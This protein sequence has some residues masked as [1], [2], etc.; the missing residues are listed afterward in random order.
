[1]RLKLF[2]Q[3]GLTYLLLL[4]LVLLGVDIYTERTLRTGYILAAE[5]QLQALER[6]A[7]PRLPPL[8]DTA[9]LQQ[10]TRWAA[11]SGAR[12]TVI[13]SDGRVLSDSDENA[14]HMENH[15]GRPEIRSALASG[16]GNAVRFS[17]TV[18]RDL[19]YLAVRLERPGLPA[20]VLRFAMP[21]QQV[22][23][24]L[25]NIR[26]RLWL[27]SGTILLLAGAVSL[28]FSR[29]FSRRVDRLKQFSHRVAQGDFRAL[30]VG[31]SGD[32]LA[33]LAATLN[34]TARNLDQSIGALTEERNRSAAIL[35]SMAEAVALIDAGERIVFYNDA[36]RSA[37][38]LTAGDFQGRPFSDVMRHPEVAAAVRAALS[39]QDRR[40]EVT[41]AL[42]QR[43]TFELTAIPVYHAGTI[44][45]LL[46]LHDITELRRLERIRRD[47]VANV[48]HEFRTP[49]TAIQGFA[50]TLLSGALEDEQNSRRFLQIIRDHA[51]RLARLTEDL[52][53]LAQI[54]AGRLEIEEQPVAIADVVETCVE[55]S[56]LR[57]EQQRL[58]LSVDVP[59]S[60]P[61]VTGDPR[62]LRDVLQNL[63]D[64]AIQYTEPG[65][66]IRINA[67]SRNDEVWLAVADT[68]IGIPEA[69]QQRIFERFYRV[70]QA[71]S[72]AAG[73]TG[74]GL[75]IARH[76]VELHG[77]RI[78]VESQ[79]GRGSTFRVRLPAAVPASV[80]GN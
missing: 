18:H 47:F 16:T 38:G 27:A 48:S 63:L 2:W 72:R 21:L 73:G 41:V 57:L 6:M 68:G 51:A 80:A 33:E 43:Q 53:R 34:E 54:D 8:E 15:A 69:D 1:M 10:W 60:L 46:V 3:L 30:P 64:N 71:R 49:L 58:K 39:G 44:A 12:V 61:P 56:R 7:Q 26:R 17:T 36:L 77:G 22:D 52:L 19:L 59:E 11:T 29:A 65:G 25:G 28:F 42:A 78:D 32:E 9:A 66:E 31:H 23:A 79:L 13:A 70:D 37:F 50:E 14:A 20:A 74:L 55:T 76:L 75:A 45:A 62:H 5:E 4:L 24:A 67:V 35:R 40:I